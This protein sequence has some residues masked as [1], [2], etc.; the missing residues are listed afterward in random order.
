VQG[1]I[2]AAGKGTRLRPVTETRSKA[3]APVAGK[4]MV[5]RVMDML[6]ANGVRDVVLVVSPADR[7]IRSYF[8]DHTPPDASIQFVEQNARLGMA[9]ALSLAAPHLQGD[10][11]LSACDN[12]TSTAHVADL[13][14]THHM[15]GTGATL[16][17]MQIELA[18]VSSTGVVELHDGRIRRIVEKPTPAA[19]PS[20]LASLPLYV[21]SPRILAYLADVRPS[22]RGEYELQD[23]IQRLIDTDGPISGVFTPNRRQLTNV[24]DLLALNRHYLQ[25]EQGQRCTAPKHVGANTQ[26]IAPICIADDVSIGA[27]CV[28]GPNVVIE[29][30]CHIGDCV[31][32][33]DAVVLRGNRIADQQ[34]ISQRVVV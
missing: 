17:L 33:R 11:V 21:F 5:A 14:A 12:L 20:T 19:A 9:N 3:M 4:P 6:C 22:P 27:N 26:L 1:V 28:I 32:M 8:A 15:Q 24:D 25:A 18:Q 34:Q 13:L 10:F 30:N 31:Q 2:L 29:C 16:S 7:A 23:A